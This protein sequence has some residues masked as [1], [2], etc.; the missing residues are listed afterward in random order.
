[1]YRGGIILKTSE[2][3]ERMAA[4]GAVQARRE[5]GL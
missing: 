4:A 2:Q 5:M 1:M 3:I